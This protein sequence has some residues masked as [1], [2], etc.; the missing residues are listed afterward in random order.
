MYEFRYWNPYITAASM[1][2]EEKEKKTPAIY[3]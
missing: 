1:K 3:I 2:A